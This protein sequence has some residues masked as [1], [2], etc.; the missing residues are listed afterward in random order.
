MLSQWDSFLKNLGEWQGSFTR[1]SPQGEK[2]A[3]TPT[4]VTIEG[5]NNNK[6][7]HQ[8]VRYLPPDEP[9]RDVV[10]DYDSLNRSILFFDNGAFSQ[11]SMQWGPYSTFGG[12][13]GLIDNEFGDGSRR[14]RMVV[15][16]SSNSQLQRVVLIREKLPDSNVLE[17]SPLTVDSLIG[18][19]QG[20]ATTVYADLSNP[21]S[22][23]SHLKVERKSSDLIEQTLSFEGRTIN[24][25]ARI[26]G[27]RLLFEKSELPTQIM[28][29][30]D[31]ASC[32][33]PLKV[34][35]GHNFVLE[36]GWLLQS[37]IRQRLMRSYNEKG[38]W[39]GCTLVTEKK[40][41]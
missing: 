25:T 9:S 39:V 7:V 19:W 10:V 36:M 29:L 37:N 31:G 18:E 12:E 41:A 14:L 24:S 11:G 2:T 15:L 8:V 6:N 26:E 23:S 3:D 21:T 27:N 35:S 33:C 28:M 13:F 22:F 20:E 34:G 30:P 38:N 4:L 1:F 40:I 16:F 17:R 32:S 5:L